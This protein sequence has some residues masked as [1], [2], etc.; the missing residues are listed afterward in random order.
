MDRQRFPIKII[1]YCKRP[2][3]TSVE[4]IISNKIHAPAVIYRPGFRMDAPVSGGVMQ[5]VTFCP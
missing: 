1:H 5:T 4:Q 3:P 2:Y